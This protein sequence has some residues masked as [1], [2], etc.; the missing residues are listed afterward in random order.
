MNLC[1]CPIVAP[2]I[3][4][5]WAGEPCPALTLEFDNDC[6]DSLRSYQ[7]KK[8]SSLNEIEICIVRMG[9]IQLDFDLCHG[10]KRP[11]VSGAM[12]GLSLRSI[13]KIF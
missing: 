11:K 13:A 5:T 4:Q 12:D 10:C 8:H 3:L 9:S 2:V 1:L 6:S 7:T